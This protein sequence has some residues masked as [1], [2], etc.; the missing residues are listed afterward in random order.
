[1]LAIG[2]H[3]DDVENLCGGTLALCAQ[4]GDELFIA[5]A[6][7]GDIGAREG[8]REEIGHVRRQE[9]ETAADRL[10]AKLIWL[11]YDDEFLFSNRE[12]RFS[13]IDAIREARPDVILALSENDYHPDHRAI[14][15]LVRDSRVPSSVPL[16]QTRFPACPIPT[17]FFMDTHDGSAFT[18]DVF[19][20]TSAVQGEKQVLIEAHRSQ[21]EWIATVFASE[22]GSAAHE[23]D[24]RRGREA[25]TEFAEAFQLLK[26]YPNTGGIELLPFSVLPTQRENEC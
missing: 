5:V 24:R 4:R 16:I 15:T 9:A 11:G 21:N 1:M 13:V 23:R 20:D 22:M 3:P 17:V 12:T 8:T 10:G 19:V 6:T 18:P 14:A 7:R 25:G 26:D 2:A